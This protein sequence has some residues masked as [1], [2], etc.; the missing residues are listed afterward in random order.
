MPRRWRTLLAAGCA[1]LV[2]GGGCGTALTHE[3]I[4][5]AASGRP[6]VSQA[7]ADD[8][9]PDRGPVTSDSMSSAER[10]AALPAAQ[11]LAGR[12]AASGP[13]GSLPA[14][15]TGAK[16]PSATPGAGS[17]TA[18][19]APTGSSPG[20]TAPAAPSVN[21]GGGCGSNCKPIVIGSVGTYSGIVGA[22]LIGGLKA[23]QSWRETV[24]AA[25]GLSGRK[26]ELISADDGGDPARHRALVQELVEQR[27]VIAF[28]YQAAPL[29]GQADIDYVTKKRIPVIGS[30]VAG[31][32]FYSSPM[33]FPQATSG[34]RML[35]SIVAAAAPI[36]LPEGRKK[37]GLITCSDG[38]Q[39]CEE[40]KKTIPDY[41]PKTGFELVW[42]GSGSLAQPDFTAECLNARNAG[43]EYIVTIVDA[44]TVR[45]LG[46]SCASVG[47]KP[48]YIIGP[49]I[50]WDYFADD[51]IFEGSI[52][53]QV[54]ATWVNTKN[55]GVAE[56]RAA[57]QR[58]APD[59]NVS[60]AAPLA[61]VSA[62]LFERAARNLP[63]QATPEAVLEGLWSIKGDTLGGLTFP[64]TF[65]RDQ[66]AAAPICAEAI[67]V[68]GGQWQVAGDFRCLEGR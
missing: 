68:R 31:E 54:V 34:K 23:L 29:S 27:G 36:A 16:A 64:L 32:W 55:P 30:E 15:A 58:F 43:A 9:A 65:E 11:D 53:T 37:L 33:F 20:V 45:R 2:V 38:I 47:Y 10:Q 24:N 41:V 60:A 21:P 50:L 52:G 44:N 63:A 1:S 4:V 40:A 14:T 28:V 26:V 3:E 57:M 5:S 13:T 39:I 8:A 17:A 19:K 59:A 7:A 18:P 22:G 46:R 67:Q 61:W 35:A 62:K 12:S 66:V 49:P 42:Q 25:G 48:R 6:A 56:Y 51:P